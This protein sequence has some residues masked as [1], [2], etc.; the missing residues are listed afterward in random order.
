[1]KNIK[2]FAVSALALSLLASNV[3]SVA[4]AEENA[5]VPKHLE[6]QKW[7]R[8]ERGVYGPATDFTFTIESGE[9]A[10]ANDQNNAV[11]AGPEG[12]V[13]FEKDTISLKPE[14]ESS[15]EK[16]VIYS[17]EKAKLKINNDKFKAPGVY[18][19]VISETVGNYAGMNYR[20]DKKY[21]DVYVKNG[22][23][24][25]MEVYAYTFVNKDNNKVKDALGGAF[26]NDYGVNP[27]DTPPIVPTLDNPNPNNNPDPEPNQNNDPKKVLSKLKVKK[28][29][30]GNQGDKQKEF[31]FKLKVV[32]DDGEK[33]NVKFSD[34]RDAVQLV[35]GGSEVS[36][37]LKHDQYAEITGLSSN[38][39]VTITEESYT[40]DGYTTKY[41]LSEN[42]VD[43]I[44]GSAVAD[45][46]ISA[47]DTVLFINEKEITTPTG[48]LLEYGPYVLL[49][50]AAAGM[51]IFSL[52]RRSEEE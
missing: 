24:G 48:L 31:T 41:K 25:T 35:S 17:A 7:V 3:P 11:L 15:L 9:A 42:V 16:N 47:N 39:K 18:R 2:K 43:E 26:I 14:V 38:D 13:T 10:N 23:N 46:T 4:R 33:Y 50:T 36:I 22:A 6:F 28:E 52:R 21:F 49:V 27:T 19:Y 12:G 44:V 1:M 20:T 29:V 34:N 32:G 5:A 8:K 30:R 40:N 37:K 45:K 51:L